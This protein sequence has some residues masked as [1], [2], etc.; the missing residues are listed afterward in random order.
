[1]T[2]HIPFNIPS[3]GPAEI[4]A[5][6]N[7]MSQDIIR[8][9]GP[10]SQR[11]QKNMEQWLSVRHA[12]LTTSCTH[13]LE[14]AMIVI[15]LKPKDEVIL[16]SYTFVSTA[17]AVL[18]RG[19][20]PVFAEISP[21]TMNI[22]PL[23]IERRI[24][25]RTKAIIPVHYAG[26]A[27]DMDVIMDIAQRHQCHVIED[28]AQ[29]VDA[30]YKGRYL[31]TIG[32]AG[33]YSFH[34]TKNIVCGEGGAFLT[35]DDTLAE[36][37]EIVREKGTNRANFIRG[38][39]DK[40]TWISEGSSYIQSD[41]LA[42]VLEAQLL[43]RAEIRD[44]RKLVWDTY[45]EALK[46]FADAGKLLLPTVPKECEHNYHMFQFRVH[47]EDLRNLLLSEL[48]S[49]HIGAA[50]HYIPLHSSPFGRNV[51]GCT[52]E[53]PVTDLCSRTIIRLPLYPKIAPMAE[54]IADAVVGVVRAHV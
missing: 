21:D 54:S 48:K 5:V 38:E 47:N 14:A 28:A 43:R 42:S 20:I 39:V 26:V 10:I 36:K 30:K 35:N 50:F 40:Y 22:D 3:I 6:T 9:D 33:C 15:G 8:G 31:G 11:V 23:D 1:M 27:C 52:E 44:A 49:N 46:P 25:S 29:G 19:G 24:T 51:V 7:A 37:F 32:H 17:N 13:A 41:I 53:L 12:Y 16:P 4:Q 2:N 45:Y 34:D 18:L